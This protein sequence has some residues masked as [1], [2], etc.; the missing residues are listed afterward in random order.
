MVL[1]VW[2]VVMG[3]VTGRGLDGALG[4]D[5]LHSVSRSRSWLHRYVDFVRIYRLCAC[6]LSILLYVHY[7][8]LTNLHT[9]K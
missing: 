4:S 3:V 2:V 8:T 1:A 6:D 5:N 7:V 9:K